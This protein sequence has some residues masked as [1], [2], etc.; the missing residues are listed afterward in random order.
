V[1]EIFLVDLDVG[2]NVMV[3]TLTKIW[4]VGKWEAWL[5]RNSNSEMGQL[6]LGVV[7]TFR[8]DSLL[9]LAK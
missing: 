6:K 7:S 5:I 4:R 9:T 1:I 2:E 8:P 3:N